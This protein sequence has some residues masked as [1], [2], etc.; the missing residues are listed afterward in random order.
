MPS[1]EL[2]RYSKTAPMPSTVQHEGGFVLGYTCHMA[3]IHWALMT[4]GKSQP[5]A[6]RIVSELARAKCPGC[7]G[8]GQHTSLSSLEYGLLFCRTARRIPSRDALHDMVAVGD[9]LITEHP[10]RPA[11]SM[12]V[13]Q[14]SRPEHITVR[15]FNNTGTLG[16]GVH[17]Q[18]DDVSHNIAKAKYWRDSECG[19]F[20][21]NGVELHVV[22][23]EIFLSIARGLRRLL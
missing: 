1:L 18:Y 8:N 3:A 17:L 16:T 4:L 11:H 22:E 2:S 14:N 12:I 21:L 6:N 13:R 5:E 20:G 19:A 15:G 23:S 9:V 10:Q 7:T